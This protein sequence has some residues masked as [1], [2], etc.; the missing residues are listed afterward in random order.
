VVATK[1]PGGRGLGTEGKQ[2]GEILRLAMLGQDEH[3]SPHA[4]SKDRARDRS[5]RRRDVARVGAPK[6]PRKSGNDSHNH[7]RE[8]KNF[9]QGLKPKCGALLMSELKLRPSGPLML[10]VATRSRRE[11]DRFRRGNEVVRLQR[12]GYFLLGFPA[13][14][15]WANFRRASGAPIA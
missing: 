11:R 15:G 6:K 12:S 4:V 9:P 3:A 8:L 1:E 10:E 13:L 2:R 7:L 14:T 5:R